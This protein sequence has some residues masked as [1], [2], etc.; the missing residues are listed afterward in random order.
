MVHELKK[1]ARV[2]S[3]ENTDIRTLKPFAS[4][5]LV[6]IDVS[7]IPLDGIA[8]AVAEW[9]ASRIIALIKPQFEVSPEI[10]KKSD[11]I[12]KSPELHAVA[13]ENATSAFE[14]VGYKRYNLI[15]SPVKGGS[16]NTEFLGFFVR[17]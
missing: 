2:L 15:E 12:I 4:V 13:I 7:F 3:L 16:G 14:K 9:G 1:D 5:D 6:V 8:S 11:G 10:A 17:Y